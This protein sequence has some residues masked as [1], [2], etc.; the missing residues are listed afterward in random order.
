MLMRFVQLLFLV[1]FCWAGKGTRATSLDF[2]ASEAAFK[3]QAIVVSYRHP[4]V[5]EFGAWWCSA[6]KTMEPVLNRFSSEYPTRF[7]VLQAEVSTL[8]DTTKQYQIESIP[9]LLFINHGNVIGRLTGVQT[10]ENIRKYYLKLT[11][12]VQ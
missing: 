10:L 12:T 11:D 6:C 3:Q 8:P 5:I 9:V 4:V 2:V 7:S 1:A